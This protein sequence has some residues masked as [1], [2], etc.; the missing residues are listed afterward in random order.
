MKGRLSEEFPGHTKNYA[1]GIIRLYVKLP[2]AREGGPRCCQ[3]TTAFLHF[4]GGACS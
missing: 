2:K 1:A 3:A 4:R